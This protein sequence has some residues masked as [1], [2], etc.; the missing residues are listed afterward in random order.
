[1]IF[2]TITKKIKNINFMSNK[3]TKQREKVIDKL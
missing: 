1:M 2:E 3:S